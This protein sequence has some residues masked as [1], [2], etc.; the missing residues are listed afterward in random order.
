MQKLFAGGHLFDGTKLHAPSLGLLVEEGRI[1]RLA[2]VAEFL[3][4]A[5]ERIDTS[6]QTLMPGLID[7][8]I[9]LTMG[10]EADPRTAQAKLSPAQMALK[11]LERAQVS[12][13]SGIV[14]LRDCGGKDFIELSVRDA[15]ARGEFEGPVV[16]ASGRVICMTGGHGSATARIA[17]GVDEVV[18]A[19]REQIHAGADFIKIMATGGVMTAGVNPEDAHYTRAEMAAGLAEAQRFHKRSASHAQGADGILNAVLGGVTSIEHGIFMNDECLRAML[20]RGTFLVPT[21]AAIRNILRHQ[22][23]GIPAWAVAKSERVFEQ[24]LQSFQMFYRAGGKIALGTDAGTPF[25]FHGENAME[26]EYMVEAGMSPEDAL[27]AGT[28]IAAD[29]CDLPDHGLLQEGKVADLLIVNGDPTRDIKNAARREN[30]RGVYK[31]GMPATG[32]PVLAGNLA[33]PLAAKAQAAF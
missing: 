28:K 32:A 30:H 11:S 26:L 27:R 18:K 12:L 16:R 6:N 20:E 13:K 33:Y 25:N 1:K 4:F 7:C 17:D 24:H 14:A 10:G 5:G 2:P 9:H 3:G 19:V 22:D 21:L 8:H 29:L 23:K 15:I 31:N